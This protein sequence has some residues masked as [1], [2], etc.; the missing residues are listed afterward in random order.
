MKTIPLTLTLAALLL[1]SHTSL[2]TTVI[3]ATGDLNSGRFDDNSF[4][5]IEIGA[6]RSTATLLGSASVTPNQ[7]AYD[8][9]SNS[10]YYTDHNGSNFYRFDTTNQT[11][12]FIAALPQ[13]GLPAGKTGS[14]AG[15]FYNGRYY[16]TPESGAQGMYQVGFSEDGSSIESHT[17]VI[18]SNLSDFSDLSDG[19]TY[20]GL[21]DFGDVAVDNTTGKMYGSSTMHN[22]GQSYTAFWSIN[23]DDPNF[24]MEMISDSLDSVYQLAFD[25]DNKL[26]GNK[27]TGGTTNQA[28]R[29]VELDQRTG[30]ELSNTRIRLDGRNARGDFYDLASTNIRIGPGILVMPEPS[31]MSLLAISAMFGLCRRSR[32]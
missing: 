1:P 24:T 32:K 11:E 7:L 19:S 17:T 21:G 14:G 5:E 29:L 28:G 3:G 25:E 27:W 30:E 15:E 13:V 22:N 31:S 23:L 10:L 2:G 20:A 4:Y 12:H 6:R 16:Y 26:W 18:P 8:V 9:D